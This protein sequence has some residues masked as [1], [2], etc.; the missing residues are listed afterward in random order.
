MIEHERSAVQGPCEFSGLRQLTRQ[1]T[2]VKGVALRC[3]E[4]QVVAET[5]T[6]RK[7]VRLCVQ[8]APEAVYQRVG[9]R[10][11][12]K[13]CECLAIGGFWTA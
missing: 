11:L 3:Q 4:A 2:K 9:G 13:Q 8:H 5:L 12:D 7:F 10:A 6:G 1:N